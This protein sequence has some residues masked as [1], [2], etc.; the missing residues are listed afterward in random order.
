M[1]KEVFRPLLFKSNPETIHEA[2]L[3]ALKVAESSPFLRQFLRKI[4]EYRDPRLEVELFGLSFK[5]P[6]GL[7]AGYDKNAEVVNALSTL[8][9]GHLEIGTVTPFPQEGSPRP[10]IFR[11]PQDKA[12]INRMGFPNQGAEKFCQNLT[13]HN[14]ESS[15]LGI[16]I[17]KGKDTLIEKASE[18]YTYLLEKVFPYAD[19]IAVNVSSPNTV[20]LRQLQAKELLSNLLSQVREKN[21]E[22]AKQRSV[23]ALPI[24]VKIA[25]DLTWSELDDI[26]EIIMAERVDGLIATNT[27]IQRP[28]F[29]KNSLRTEVGGLSGKPL[30]ARSTEIIRYAFQRTERKLP[31]IGVGGVFDFRDVIEKIAA[32]A[33][34]I[35]VFTGLAYE[36]PFMVKTINRS[37]VSY[38]ESLGISS[39]AELKGTKP[40]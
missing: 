36:G 26:L 35:Q 2:T 18:D 20:G 30:K 14:K 27:T 19:Y 40:F 8:G 5:N 37:L 39:I 28:V 12:A 24:L 1:Y 7:A 31:I 4:F 29:L 11:L 3:A 17:G 10:R 13:K 22:T 16:N 32:G 21:L 6:L 23:K 33:S 15:V 34:L 38:M 9:F 25:P